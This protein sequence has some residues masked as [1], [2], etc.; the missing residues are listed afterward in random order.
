MS[1]VGFEPTIAAGE[2]PYLRHRPRGH[3]DWRHLVSQSIDFLFSNS[4]YNVAQVSCWNTAKSEGITPQCLIKRI[5][6]RSMSSGYQ[7]GYSTEVTVNFAPWPHDSRA[8]LRWVHI[9]NFTAYRNTV[10]W[11]CW[12]DSWPRNVSTVGD[13]VTLWAIS[14]RCRYLAV[15]SK[16]W[17][18]YG[19]SRSERATWHV[20]T[21]RSSRILYIHDASGSRNKLGTPWCNARRILL[22]HEARDESSDRNYVLCQ[23]LGNVTALRNAVTLQVC[24]HLYSISCVID[25]LGLEFAWTSWRGRVSVVLRI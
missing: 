13:A 3:C 4:W 9:C 23:S 7:A 6:C 21:A 22:R 18:R 5:L 11:Q 16:G 24:A 17:N 25:L 12:G 8:L 19:L 20:I 14:V 15:A 1:P 10:S 2:L